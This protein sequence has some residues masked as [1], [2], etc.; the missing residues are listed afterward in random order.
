MI[1]PSFK[2][3]IWA[4]DALVEDEA[5]QNK[6][7]RTV[8]AMVRSPSVIIEPVYILSPDQLKLS[9]EFY[10]AEHGNFK[11]L[12]QK[13]LE[14]WMKKIKVAGLS[15]P[16]VLVSSDLSLK[17]AASALLSYAKSVNADLI[18]LSTHARKGVARFLLGSFA[19]TLAL[20]SDIPLLTVN[21]KSDVPRKITEIVFPTDFSERSK[22]AL[23]VVANFAKAIDAKITLYHQVE[24]LSQYFIEPMVAVPNYQSFIE[25]DIKR[26]KATA[27]EW[28][29][30]L[31]ALGV[32]TGEV[33]NKKGGYAPDSILSYAKK[34][35][36]GMI[37]MA[38]QS[39][40]LAATLLGSVTRQVMRQSPC[41]LWVVHC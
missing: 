39:G 12:A 16:T 7:A 19:E 37:A 40:S 23:I 17:S 21:P 26:R 36:S 15:K 35:K 34:L 1:T 2:R 32:K 11:L 13:R 29:M 25:Q 8:A 31:T 18:A 27:E 14:N 38:S 4:I 41:P 28:R 5:L 22:K 33:I 6:C 3:V 9:S 20:H 30:E 24:Y 10:P